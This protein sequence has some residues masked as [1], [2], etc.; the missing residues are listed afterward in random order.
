MSFKDLA[1]IEGYDLDMMEMEIRRLKNTAGNIAWANKQVISENQKLEEE[2]QG[3][4][5]Q[6][7]ELESE[8]RAYKE[9][10]LS[11]YVE[12]I[13]Q[14]NGR[15]KAYVAALEEENKKLK[16]DFDYKIANGG[17]PLK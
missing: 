14:E 13:C 5:K 4:K 16:A 6:L 1:K 2:K 15:L 9:M 7:A 11:T 3:L 10:G 8:N 17:I 12:E